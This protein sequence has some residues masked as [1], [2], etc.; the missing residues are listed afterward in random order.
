MQLAS[1]ATDLRAVPLATTSSRRTRDNSDPSIEIAAAFKS[2]CKAYDAAQSEIDRIAEAVPE[3]WFGPSGM[4][5][6]PHIQLREA[7]QAALFDKISPTFCSAD[8]VDERFA[9]LAKKFRT[10]AAT[11]ARLPVLAAE[12]K[13]KIAAFNAEREPVLEASGLNKASETFWAVSSDRNAAASSLAA[14]VPATPRG[15]Q[16]LL[17]AMTFAVSSR[18][19]G[20]VLSAKEICKIARNVSAFIG[21]GSR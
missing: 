7:D 13:D 16:A 20:D 5:R 6:L 17:S 19:G 4:L 2:A 10:D 3:H 15:A 8:E 1:C 11:L 18:H 14:A 21:G 12:L 9:K